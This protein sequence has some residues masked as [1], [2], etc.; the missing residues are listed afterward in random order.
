MLN[1][2]YVSIAIGILFCISLSA[3]DI[4]D[5][6]YNSIDGKQQW[7]LKTALHRIL[8]NHNVLRYNDMWYYY[9]T[10]DVRDDGYTVWD[11]Y[12]NTV[13]YFNSN[14]SGSTSGM[15][16]EH[17][18]P[19]SWWAESSQVEKYD[20][21]TDL[22]HL[23]PADGPANQAKS[24][25][26]LDEVTGAITFNNNVSKVGRSEHA[27]L[28]FEPADEYKGD[29]A[30]TYFY[31][32]TCYEDY[33]QQWRSDA[34]Y[35]FNNET[36]QILKPWA[37]ELLMKWHRNDPVGSKEI[38]RN[39]AVYGHQGNRNPYIDFP[40]LAEYMW[41]DSVNVAFKLP[42]DLKTQEPVLLIPAPVNSELYIGS[43][44]KDS[45]I[46]K[47]VLIKGVGLKGN[48]QVMLFANTSGYFGLNQTTVPSVLANS[49]AGY[50]L[51]VT[52]NPKDYGEHTASLVIYDGGISGSVL[53]P[54]KG[55]CTD[56]ISAIIPIGSKYADL[57]SENGSIFF[58]TYTPTDR[59]YI[60]DWQGRVV[61]Q[62]T[63]SGDWQ[64]FRVPAP[65]VYI[66]QINRLARKIF[67]K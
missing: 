10:T 41:G 5:G 1:K 52:Y 13:R 62:T 57:Y 2:K 15:E 29:F 20:A 34:L 63:C 16:R 8:K 9:H 40:K 59:I 65:G 43:I 30:R 14:P 18:L 19:K 24:N 37:K 3:Q 27:S 35:M 67:V 60:R 64:G 58:R 33:A 12:S 44:R 45:E 28:V 22:H 38:L 54:L 51:K 55:I 31:M 50:S 7:D 6:Y 23:Y 36:S 11:M 39:E 21:Y 47:T 4:P 66:V 32:I 46:E 53:V 26:I 56:N 25:H 17:S 61:Y 48:L 49:E 42:E